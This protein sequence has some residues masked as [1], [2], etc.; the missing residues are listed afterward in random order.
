MKRDAL[1]QTALLL[2]LCLCPTVPVAMAEKAPSVMFEPPEQTI[3]ATPPLERSSTGDKC[4]ELLRKIEALKGKP[5]QRH[6]A[7][8][9]YQQEC[10]QNQP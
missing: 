8:E 3:T 5:Q 4:E 7:R 2:C 10:T 6:T 1:T 9:R